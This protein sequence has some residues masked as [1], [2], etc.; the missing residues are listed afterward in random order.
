MTER[1]AP[2]SHLSLDVKLQ[3]PVRAS[4]A[5][6]W[7][8]LTTRMGD[9]MRSYPGREHMG[10]VLEARPGGML[11]RPFPEGGGCWWATVRYLKPLHRLDL[12]GPFFME[13]PSVT[14]IVFTLESATENKSNGPCTLSVHHRIMGESPPEAEMANEAWRC[15]LEE[16]YIPLSEGNA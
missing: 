12:V 15:F 5:R 16:F 2:T 3:V 7:E 14:T 1:L 8:I 11:W 9:W 13:G 6:A 10:L 4:R